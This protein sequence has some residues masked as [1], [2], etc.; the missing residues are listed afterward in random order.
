[1]CKLSFHFTEGKKTGLAQQTIVDRALFLEP[2][3]RHPQPR[4]RRLNLEA[5]KLSEG[6][7]EQLRRHPVPIEEA[8]V[9]VLNNKSAG[10]DCYLWLAYRRTS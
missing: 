10:L 2:E 6:F 1:M 4:Q 8:A 3:E 5:A 9:K 7:F